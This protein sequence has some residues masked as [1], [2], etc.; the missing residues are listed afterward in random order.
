M[1][2]ALFF[3]CLSVLVIYCQPDVKQQGLVRQA[4]DGGNELGYAVPQI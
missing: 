2:K 3:S 1:S 4:E